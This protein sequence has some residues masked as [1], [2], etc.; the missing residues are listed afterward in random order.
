MRCFG[1]FVVFG[2]LFASVS[3]A[4]I[5][6]DF[7]ENDQLDGDMVG[8]TA[9]YFDPTAGHGATLTTTAGHTNM[10]IN[11]GAGFLGLGPG[12]STRFDIG[13]FWEF[14]WSSNAKFKSLS[15]GQ[16]TQNSDVVSMQSADWIGGA[17][18]PTDP[19][20]VTFVSA[21]GT[22]NFDRGP[23]GGAAQT[24]T[25]NDLTGGVDLILS[26]GT[27]VRF[28]YSAGFT[29]AAMNQMVWAIP[30]P[31]NAFVVALSLMGFAVYRR[32]KRSI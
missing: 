26:A 28:S 6:I 24:W 17:F 14:T 31:C 1:A 18:T 20:R 2:V 21:T 12:T 25:L 4:D 16:L 9:F 32:K 11:T 8:D 3:H 13:E 7:S 5:V 10:F 15:F 29:N 23:V 30:E 27:G 22:F 19:A